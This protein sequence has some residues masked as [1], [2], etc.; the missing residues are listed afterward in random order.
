[1]RT[2]I[3]PNTDTFHAVSLTNKTQTGFVDENV[4]NKYLHQKESLEDKSSFL[5]LQRMMRTFEK[6]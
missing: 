5:P 4:P 6:M 1:M 3:T 2:R